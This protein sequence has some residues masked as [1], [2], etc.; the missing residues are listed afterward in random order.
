MILYCNLKE[1]K[2]NEIKKESKAVLKL[3]STKLKGCISSLADQE[4]L[5][6]FLEKNKF[7]QKQLEIIKNLFQEACSNLFIVK[8]EYSK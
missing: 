3:T 1:V 6:K 2:I 4:L 8:I 7:S 5:N